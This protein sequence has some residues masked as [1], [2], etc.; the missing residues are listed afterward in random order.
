[1]AAQPWSDSRVGAYGTSSEAQAAELI[2]SLRNPHVVALAALVSPLGP[3]REL[4]YPGACAA[5]GRFARRMCE[6]QIQDGVAG[7]VERRSEPTSGS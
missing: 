7:A 2:A 4:F 1:V 5:G 3:Y 6:S